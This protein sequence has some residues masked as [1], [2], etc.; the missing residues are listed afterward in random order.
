MNLDSLSRVRRSE[1]FIGTWLSIGSPIIAELAGA[2]EFL[3]HGL[4]LKSGL[5]LADWSNKLEAWMKGRGL[6]DAAK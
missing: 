6:L 4:G 1:P 5:P 3:V 2:S